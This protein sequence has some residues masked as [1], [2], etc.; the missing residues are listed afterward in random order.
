MIICNYCPSDGVG[1]VSLSVYEWG[2]TAT[3]NQEPTR[4]IDVCTNVVCM[5]KALNEV[6]DITGASGVEAT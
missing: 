4:R 6:A 3:N 1:E 5:G 2:D